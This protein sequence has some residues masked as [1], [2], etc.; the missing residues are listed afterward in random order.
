MISSQAHS[1]RPRRLSTTDFPC[2]RFASRMLPLVSNSGAR[3]IGVWPVDLNSTIG[4]GRPFS[5]LE[6]IATQIA[7]ESPARVAHD[8]RDWNNR[9]ARPKLGT[10][11]GCCADAEGLTRQTAAI[12]IDSLQ[13]VAGPRQFMV[14]S[15]RAHV[16][17][18][19]VTDRAA[20]TGRG[21]SDDSHHK[22]SGR[23]MANS[24][25]RGS[26]RSCAACCATDWQPCPVHA[27]CGNSI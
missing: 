26:T 9:H 2:S 6:V 11:C 14:V 19:G 18:G 22:S 17:R 12:K 21:H 20:H 27:E 7:H 5:D 16:L 3:L 25:P 8:G 15:E 24:A 23:G 1:I 10:P 13:R 4:R